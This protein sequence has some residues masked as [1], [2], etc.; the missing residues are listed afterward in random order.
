MSACEEGREMDSGVTG[1]GGLKSFGGVPEKAGKTPRNAEESASETAEVTL[2]TARN[3][4]KPQ[5]P[6]R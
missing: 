2:G 5:F 6:Y 1:F 4:A 3:L